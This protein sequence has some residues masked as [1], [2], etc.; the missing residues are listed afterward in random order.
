VKLGAAAGALM[1]GGVAVISKAKAQG[2][3]GLVAAGGA[4]GLIAA[5]RMIA[6]AID[7]G[8]LRG[9]LRS[10]SLPDAD[11]H[12]GRLQLMLPSTATAFVLWNRQKRTIG[13]AGA[14]RSGGALT[15]FPAVRFTF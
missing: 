13:A 2:T 7:A 6:P 11:A 10:S 14:T 4:L 15:N 8:P 3:F 12:D 5:D 9:V 1:G